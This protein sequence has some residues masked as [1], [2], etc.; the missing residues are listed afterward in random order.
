MTDFGALPVSKT[1]AKQRNVEL[2]R[3][4]KAKLEKERKQRDKEEAERRSIAVQLLQDKKNVADAVRKSGISRTTGDRI[5]AAL[6]AGDEAR[7]RQLLNP[8]GNRAGRRS[9]L[10]QDENEMLKDRIT[11][12]ASRGFAF[13]AP[14][15]KKTM[16]DIASDGR[17]GFRSES[18][19]PS[20][21][22]LRYWRACNRDITFRTAENK[23]SASLIAERHEHVVTFKNAFQSI[24]EKH[25]NI[26]SDPDRL[27]NLDETAVSGEFG[28]KVKV[29]GSSGT[30]HGG[31]R[32]QKGGKAN[33]HV[34]AVVA[35][36]ASGRK[37]P[38]FF[39]VS[40]KN[41]MESWLDPL[42]KHQVGSERRYSGSARPTGLS[43][44]FCPADKAYCLTL[45]G[46][47]SRSGL[48]WL[49]YCSSVGCERAHQSHARNHWLLCDIAGLHFSKLFRFWSVACGFPLHEPI[50]QG[51]HNKTRTLGTQTSSEKAVENTRLAS[52]VKRKSDTEV[53]NFIQETASK[54]ISPSKGLQIL[55]QKLCEHKSVNK[56]LMQVSDPRRNDGHITRARKKTNV[57]LYKGTLALC[58][59]LGDMLR[60]REQEEAAIKERELQKHLANSRKL[61]E[62]AKRK[63]EKE[64]ETK[65]KSVKR[66][67]RKA[68]K[69]VPWRRNCRGSVSQTMKPTRPRRTNQENLKGR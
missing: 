28:K 36:S 3:Q 46:H 32:A 43:G 54:K 56:I 23:R 4:K 41:V 9:V 67:E 66:A 17:K 35:V 8:A 37:A 25:A 40:G 38:P 53:W 14:I 19:T 51:E 1:R 47:S 62:R 61:E 5:N 45:D 42:E 33:K 64:K 65:M 55:E 58:L 39:I 50:S 15:L 48:D 29:F 12:T 11:Y 16:A 6:K 63:L 34:T 10:T 52:V 7:L 60:H 22:S 68:A 30:H 26:F 49:N 59:T 18:G 27:W 24:Q 57:A 13:D 31:S 69:I 44:T 2:A 21:D 20:D